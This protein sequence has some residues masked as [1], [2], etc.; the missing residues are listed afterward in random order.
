[1]V[2][3]A[4]TITALKCLLDWHIDIDHVQ[5]VRNC[6]WHQVGHRHCGLKGLFL[7]ATLLCSMVEGVHPLLALPGCALLHTL[8]VHTDSESQGKVGSRSS[9][10]PSAGE[11]DVRRSPGSTRDSSPLL[12]QWRKVGTKGRV[13]RF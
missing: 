11:P 4:D 7:C 3:A 2:F 8:R 9:T 5:G 13:R 6:S 10:M 1:M 12:T